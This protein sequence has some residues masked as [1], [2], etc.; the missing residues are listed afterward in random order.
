M[1]FRQTKH[2]K[3]S[4]ENNDHGKSPSHISERDNMHY[5]FRNE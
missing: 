4:S 1:H 2:E 3:G 5:K